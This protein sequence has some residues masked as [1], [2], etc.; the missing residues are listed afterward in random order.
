MV[1]AVWSPGVGAQRF[2]PDNPDPT[3]H[4]AYASFFGSGWYR[5]TDNQSAFI[6]S[7]A[8][9]WDSREVDLITDLPAARL[10]ASVPVTVGIAD[11]S[12]DD[13]PSAL[14]PDNFLAGS[15]GLATDLDI[16]LGERWSLRPHAQLSVGSQLSDPNTTL[17]YRVDLRARRRH[18]LL[19]Q[20]GALVGGIGTVGYSAER[21]RDD[22]FDY[23]ELGAEFTQPLGR[24]SWNGGPD[25]IHAH[26]NYAYF[27]NDI[28]VQTSRSAVT[29]TSD[30]WEVGFALGRRSG[31]FD[32]GWFEL[33]RIGLAL[34]SSTSAELAGVK[35]VF[36][37]LYDF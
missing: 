1:V 21:G 13:V 24:L 11:L 20:A 27:F 4:W 17:T 33:D 32:F 30:A 31:A 3:I 7:T 10:T 19:G 34:T 15:I 2:L 37:S 35:L 25:Q 14:N 36:N 6:L 28:I 22:S 12:L 18:T 26:L 5:L 23:A 9:E 29:R 8:P 16:S